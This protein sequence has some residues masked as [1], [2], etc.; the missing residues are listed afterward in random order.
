VSPYDTQIQI[1]PWRANMNFVGASIVA[2]NAP[3]TLQGDYHLQAGSPAIDTG[4]A[5]GAPLFDFDG[6]P[7]PQGCGIDIGADEDEFVIPVQLYLSKDGQSQFPG[8]TVPFDDADIYAWDGTSFYCFWDA[9]AAGLPDNA[10]I[11]AM[12]VNGTND[13]YLTL[14]PALTLPGIP[15][16][17]SNQDIVYYKDGT[18]S[19]AFDGSD[20]GL[21]DTDGI[22]AF[23]LLPDGTVVVSLEGSARLPGGLR[24]DGEDLVQCTG[25]YGPDTACT[26]SIYFDGSDIRLRSDV[27][28][29]R[30]RN[31]DIYL[32]T[33][34]A[35]SVGDVAGGPED[36][37][38]CHGATTGADSACTSY[39]LYF[40]GS[41]FGITNNVTAFDLH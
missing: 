22:D 26:W 10:R 9:S 37:F 39:S 28:G 8:V 1:F 13:F 19:L 35:F 41:T 6:D 40:D 2:V 16:T 18:W 38:V 3:I 15:E 5:M 11:K 32:S 20:V 17:I 25:T 27:D 34:S 31:G 29:V 24:V 4:T 33:S 36:V 23:D 21:E 12:V 30:V 14:A 7:R